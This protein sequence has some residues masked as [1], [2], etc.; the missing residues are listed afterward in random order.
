MKKNR[1]LKSLGGMS[2][3][4]HIMFMS[5]KGESNVDTSHLDLPPVYDKD[6][7][8]GALFRKVKNIPFIRGLALIF[9]MFFSMLRHLYKNKPL[10][11]MIIFFA[12]YMIFSPSTPPQE[13]QPKS[14]FWESYLSFGIYAV[15][16]GFI[17]YARE[18]HAAEHKVIGAYMDGQDISFR[19][20]K[21]QP[22]EHRRCG[23]VLVVW[24][25]SIA[26]LFELI[27]IPSYIRTPLAI[28]IGYEAF[29]LAAKDTKL[30]NVFFYPGWLGQKLTTK[31]PRKKILLRSRDGLR[32]LLNEEKYPYKL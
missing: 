2:V 24:I 17:F 9:D 29:R 31:E 8:N 6:P 18:N 15:L 11:F 20:I 19:N 26:I 5:D 25:L 23:T 4:S 12:I 10:F 28:S 22:K 27:T 3:P 7:L 32:K 21:K 13:I 16:L 1:I 14:L 30:G